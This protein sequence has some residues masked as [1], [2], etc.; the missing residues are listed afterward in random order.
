MSNKKLFFSIV[1]FLIAN[2][3]MTYF[4][5]AQ[6]FN[7][8][9]ISFNRT[10]SGEVMSIL[11]NLSILSLIL[12][13]IFMFVKRSDK[14]VLTMGITTLILGIII[15]ALRVY[16]K[17][18]LAFFSFRT[19]SVFRNPAAN[20][21]MSIA[22]ETVK[23]FFVSF[24]FLLLV[25]GI[26]FIVYAYFLR[27]QN[28]HYSWN[29]SIKSIKYRIGFI[30]LCMLFSYSSILSFVKKAEKNW[31]YNSDLPHYGVMNAGVYNYYV[32]ELFGADFRY[33]YKEYMSKD[34]I[35]D[36]ILEFNRANEGFVNIYQETTDLS[37]GKG[38]FKDKN[39]YILQLES[40]NNF[41]IDLEVNG[42]K[43]MPFLSNFI[44]NDS[45]LYYFENMYS[46]VGQGNTADAELS[47]MCGVNPNGYSTLHW[48]YEDND[49]K[50]SSLPY[51]FKNRYENSVAYSFHGDTEEFYNRT[52][53]HEQMFGFDEYYSLED[54]LKTHK[55]EHKGP[56]SFIQGWVKDDVMIKW[57]DE[58]LSDKE[59]YLAFNI[60]TVSHT[61]Y[62][63]NPLENSFNWK[64]DSKLLHRYL[65]YMRYVDNYLELFF[66]SIK[67][68]TDTLFIIYSD[69]GSGLYGAPLEELYGDIDYMQE[70]KYMMQVPAMIYDPSGT[71]NTFTGGNMMQPLL[72]NQIDL[73][74]T[75][76]SLMDLETPDIVLGLNA[77]TDERTFAYNPTNFC[78][79][80]DNY[81]YSVKD[82]SAKY[83]DYY[84]KSLAKE[85]IKKIKRYKLYIEVAIRH[86]L[87][88]L[89]R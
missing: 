50:F 48:E 41:V 55:S 1:I 14:R 22:L 73:Y 12:I 39:L 4:L 33:D 44:K 26:G 59:Q 47:V 65:S 77:L 19:L 52:P 8:F 28:Y 15:Y 46:N 74:T 40:I 21:G 20:L 23:D 64:V 85:E 87:F 81:I 80:T 62:V 24:S 30:I 10:F 5:T 38:L 76:I 25:P 34:E 71:L 13:F 18:Y 45:N 49:F 66:N 54:Y 72:R 61:P 3:I 2:L 70:F 84:D 60:M 75:I 43:V 69:H 36:K 51:L 83:Y 82:N 79:F 31:L 32:Y 29:N 86:N 6:T 68:D 58:I 56:N 11:G 7:S 37:Y 35:S 27:R 53:V 67:D 17:Y 89:K 63:G 57:A 9:I 42:I 16:T 88:E 78:V